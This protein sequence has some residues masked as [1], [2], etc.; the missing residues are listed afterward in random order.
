MA[1]QEQVGLAERFLATPVGEIETLATTKK[2]VPSAQMKRATSAPTHPTSEF[3]RAR[4]PP[5][6][7]AMPHPRALKGY[8]QAD[9]TVALVVVGVGQRHN[10]GRHEPIGVKRNG[11]GVIAVPLPPDPA[12]EYAATPSQ[13]ISNS[14]GEAV[15]D[16]GFGHLSQPDLFL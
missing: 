12:C 9:K 1:A 14:D 15:F 6:A 4:E 10:W 8:R 16:G 13:D 2:F 7:P 3:Q 5:A 11:R